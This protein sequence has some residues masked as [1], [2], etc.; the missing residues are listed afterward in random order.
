MLLDDF[1]FRVSRVC[2]PLQPGQDLAAL[3]KV[4]QRLLVFALD[5]LDADEEHTG[6]ERPHGLARRVVHPIQK[7]GD[8]LVVLLKREGLPGAG[9]ADVGVH[10]SLEEALMQAAHGQDG[11]SDGQDGVSDGRLPVAYLQDGDAPEN[12]IEVARQSRCRDVL[13][14]VEGALLHRRGPF[15]QPG[16]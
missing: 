5:E 2:P 1:D 11:V 10:G 8:G 16:Q 12:S 13:E 9:I 6:Q 4:Y 7:A 14:E 3:L 15:Q